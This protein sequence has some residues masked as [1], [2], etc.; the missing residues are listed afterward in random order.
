M[1]TDQPRLP[2]DLS[3]HYQRWRIRAGSFNQTWSLVRI[4]LISLSTVF[5]AVVLGISIA[6]AVDPAL[7]SYIAVWTCPQ[8]GAAVLWSGIE[9]ITA[10]TGRKNDRDI[11]PGAHAF[12]QL[13]LWFSFGAGAGL[14]AY[15]LA[16]AVAFASNKYNDGYPDYYE[17]HHNG[18]RYQYYSKY[19]IRSMEAI[20]AFLALLIIIHFLL[21]VG[22]CTQVARRKKMDNAMVIG[23][24]EEQFGHP[25]QQLQS[26]QLPQ[27]Y[28][29]RT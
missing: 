3:L 10:H 21:F 7:Q 1:H 15:I 26:V 23:M 19:Y 18:D 29:K 6:L 14:T 27:K 4:V 8:A 22:A 2:R 16:F 12:V 28:E 17:Y 20:V 13:L 25:M 24:S 9:L 5:C 11:H